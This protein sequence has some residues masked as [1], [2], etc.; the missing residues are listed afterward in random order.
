[1]TFPPSFSKISA[2]PEPIDVLKQQLFCLSPWDTERLLRKFELCCSDKI[3]SYNGLLPIYQTDLK[4]YPTC[5]PH[6]Y[7]EILVTRQAGNHSL[8]VF[9]QIA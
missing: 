4:I 2:F 1:M 8:S 3:R 6:I 7:R 9:G 5:Y